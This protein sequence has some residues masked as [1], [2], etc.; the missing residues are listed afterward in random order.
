[1]E[2]HPGLWKARPLDK[3]PLILIKID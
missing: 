3:S 2:A 1:V